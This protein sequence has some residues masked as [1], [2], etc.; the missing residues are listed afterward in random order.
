MKQSP[1]HIGINLSLGRRE[2]NLKNYY[3][4]KF[5][6]EKEMIN[7]SLYLRCLLVGIRCVKIG[8][9]VSGMPKF[10]NVLEIFPLHAILIY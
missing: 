3:R 8:Q 2:G 4:S 5:Q 9:A 10:V 6:Q 1:Y 7:K